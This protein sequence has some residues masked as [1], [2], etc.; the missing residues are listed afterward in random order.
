MVSRAPIEDLVHRYADAVV[1]CDESRWAATWAEDAVWSLGPGHRADGRDA[2]VA[3]WVAAMDAFAA[4]VQVVAN[5]T[6]EL[7]D[8]AGTGTGRW[9]VVEH[10]S[11]HDGSRNVMVGHY[12]DEYAR[13]DGTWC[14]ARRELSV[15]DAG[16]PEP[17]APFPNSTG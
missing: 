10:L 5:G 14:F 11:G 9:Y 3:A 4:V 8:A 13:T 7:D 6:Y 16:P 17:S 1:H 15:H 12:D 2:I